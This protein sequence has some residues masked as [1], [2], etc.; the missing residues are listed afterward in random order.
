M[1]KLVEQDTVTDLV[2]SM[3]VL[4]GFTGRAGHSNRLMFS[5]TVL[6]V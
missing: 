4:D 1:Y 3:T 5:L 6:D 2:F